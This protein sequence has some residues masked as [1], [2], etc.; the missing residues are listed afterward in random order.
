[1]KGPDFGRGLFLFISGWLKDSPSPSASRNDMSTNKPLLRKI[2]V[3]GVSG[4]GKTRLAEELSRRLHLPFLPTDPLYWKQ[5]WQL[6]P[7]GEVMATV[8]KHLSQDEWVLDGN[9]EEQR[10]EIWP[11][12]DTIIWLDYPR[13]LVLG[14]VIRRNLSWFLTRKK[15]WSGNQMS[16]TQ[17]LSGIRHSWRSY[18]KKKAIYAQFLQHFPNDTVLR[19]QSP[20]EASKWLDSLDDH[21]KEHLSS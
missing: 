1:M 2:L 12:A 21:L 8:R 10:A 15:V 13:A 7:L 3:I 17:T 18:P 16:L 20:E 5:N 11:Q 4:S 9:F 19:F 14:R 6:V